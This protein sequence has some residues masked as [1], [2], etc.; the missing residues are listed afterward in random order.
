MGSLMVI[1]EGILYLKRKRTL[2][3]LLQGQSINSLLLRDIVQ[4]FL[5]LL[6]LGGHAMESLTLLLQ[7]NLD[8]NSPTSLQKHFIYLSQLFEACKLSSYWLLG[9]G[10]LSS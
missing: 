3:L 9:I 8:N 1:K 2:I 5:F 4:L 10:L 7:M 6:G